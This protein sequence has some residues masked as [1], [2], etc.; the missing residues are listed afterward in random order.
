MAVPYSTTGYQ[1]NALSGSG[2]VKTLVFFTDPLDPATIRANSFLQ[3]PDQVRCMAR[4]GVGDLDAAAQ[5]HL[6]FGC[7]N[8]IWILDGDPRA[9]NAILRQ[10]TAN[11]GVQAQTL[12]AETQFGLVMLATDGQLYL[13]GGGATNL[14]PLGTPV[15]D[16]FAQYTDI[17]RLTQPATLVWNPP[18]LHVYGIRST[19][20]SL[21]CD[22]SDPATPIWTGPHV[23][24]NVDALTNGVMGAIVRPQT[25]TTADT[26]YLAEWGVVGGMHIFDLDTTGSGRSQELRTG[27]VSVA[28]HDV[29]CNRVIGEFI[30]QTDGEDITVTAYSPAGSE[31]VRALPAAG[32]STGVNPIVRHVFTFT[33]PVHGDALVFKMIAQG[34]GQLNLVRWWAEIRIEPAQQSVSAR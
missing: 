23:P 20:G 12:M 31:F 1:A 13:L 15:R 8:S 22:L 32:S 14:Q 21:I 5:S 26:I 2:W 9:G 10:L 19:T 3:I 17:P 16:Q 6:V 30:R 18:L 24:G 29:A 11:L 28:G 7:R 34:G 4:T 27:A 33:T 25:S